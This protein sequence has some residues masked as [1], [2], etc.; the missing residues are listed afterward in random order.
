MIHNI[1]TKERKTIQLSVPNRCRKL[2]FH[3]LHHH[4]TMSGDMTHIYWAVIHSGVTVCRLIN[5]MTTPNVTQKSKCSSN[6]LCWAI[7]L[8]FMMALLGVSVSGAHSVIPG[9]SAA[10]TPESGPV[11]RSGH[12]RYNLVQ[13]QSINLTPLYRRAGQRAK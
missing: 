12:N 10:L 1:Q 8:D 9:S 6:E 4:N 13:N 3:V 7:R 5:R 2:P 11:T